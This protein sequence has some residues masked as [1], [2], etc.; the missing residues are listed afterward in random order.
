MESESVAIINDV[1]MQ[2]E[3]PAQLR[4]SS[5]IVFFYAATGSAVGL[6]GLWK[7]PYEAGVHGGGAFV[8]VFILSVLVFGMPLLMAELMI[9]RRGRGNPAR[10]THKVAIVSKRSHWWR[11][12]GGL[13]ALAGFLLLTYYVVIIGWILAHVYKALSGAYLHKSV[14]ELN[15]LFASFMA[16]PTQMIFWQL[17]V[18]GLLALVLARGLKKG[19]ERV[20]YLMFPGMLLTMG[21]L[22]I[23]AIT[24]GDMRQAL[25]FLFY[26]D[27]QALS[28]R[29]A[30][31]AVGLAFMSLSLAQGIMIMYGAYLPRVVSIPKLTGAIVFGDIFFA[32]L[33]GLITFP[34]VFAYGL[35]PAEGPSLLFVT[36]PVAFSQMPLGNLCAILFFTVFFFAGFTSAISLLEPTVVWMM[37]R[38][39]LGRVEAVVISVL[40]L[41]FLG[42]GSVFSFNHWAELKILGMTYFEVVDYSLT[43]VLFPLCGFLTAIFCGWAV[44]K[45]ISQKALQTGNN[46]I[47]RFWHVSLRYIAPLAIGLI[48]LQ[49]MGI[50]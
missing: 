44:D 31:V 23:F 9:G 42:L 5:P 8:L 34:F 17:I 1:N 16:S 45:A 15:G 6:G 39:G 26:P 24:N 40:T 37:E 20:S 2:T 19:I 30:L 11:W 36:L 18:L 49:F 29:G 41:F 25:H 48:F 35:A 12:L 7:F 22:L 38:Y 28:V 32:L 46:F 10:A 13:G 3:K 21:I 4:W 27:F 33:A 43:H 50:F 47:Y 14:E